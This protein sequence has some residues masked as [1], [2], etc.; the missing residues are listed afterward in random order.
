MDDTSIYIYTHCYIYTNG[1]NFR[2]SILSIRLGLWG[3]QLLVFLCTIIGLEYSILI[4]VF[5]R[6]SLLL[7]FL[8]FL[9]WDL[10]WVLLSWFPLGSFNNTWFPLRL[11][12]IVSFYIKDPVLCVVFTAYC[13]FFSF[14]THS[15][16]SSSFFF[17]IFS[18]FVL[19]S[20]RV[21]AAV[22]ISISSLGLVR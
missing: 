13:S 3:L 21:S 7:C 2:R 4:F 8:F 19:V 9:M 15:Y 10:Q 1:K 20:A 14:S 22:L 17:P 16:L 11:L 6:L 12:A 18:F 5:W